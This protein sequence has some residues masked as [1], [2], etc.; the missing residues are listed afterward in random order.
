MKMICFV[1]TFAYAGL[2][3]FLNPQP[4]FADITIVGSA[5]GYPETGGDWLSMGINDIDGSGGLGTDGFLIFGNYNG[6][7]ATNQT[8][9]NDVR[10]TPVYVSSFSAG[11]NFHSIADELVGYGIIDEPNLLDGTNTNGGV[12][13][14]F[15]SGAGSSVEIFTF[16]VSGLTP[17]RVVRVGILSGTEGNLDGRW[18]PTSI[19]LSEGVNSGTVGNHNTSQL[20]QNPG[21]TNTG[22]VFFDIN[23]NGTYGVSGTARLATQG[24]GFGGITFDSITSIP[25][26]AFGGIL[27]LCGLILTLRY[28]KK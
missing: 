10:N 19:T 7:G 11:A 21:G 14:G 1:A 5:T 15:G 16:D 6:V 20:A 9:G 27:V 22:W 24:V 23:A 12:A 28:R 13:V 25:E 17:G 4:C 2:I 3:G 8:F 18:D 26:P